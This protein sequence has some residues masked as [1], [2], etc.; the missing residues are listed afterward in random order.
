MREHKADLLKSWP[1]LEREKLMLQILGSD[2]V[3][4][5]SGIYRLCSDPTQSCSKNVGLADVARS[6]SVANCTDA[7]LRSATAQVIP[8]NCSANVYKTFY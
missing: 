2:W 7:D 3:A 1:V 5:E 4:V 6:R 8:A